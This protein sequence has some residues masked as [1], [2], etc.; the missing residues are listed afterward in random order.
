M[1][2]PKEGQ[3]VSRLTL[4][5]SFHQQKPGKKFGDLCSGEYFRLA[6][7]SSKT[8]YMKVVTPGD[9][10]EYGV[11]PEGAFYNFDADYL[12]IRMKI[13]LEYDGDFDA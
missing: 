9:S 11:T 4:G 7:G 10:K 13:R 3:R 8:P 12:V 6:D 5:T 2:F 1:K